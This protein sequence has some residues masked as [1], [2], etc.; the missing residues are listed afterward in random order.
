MV[1]EIIK[2]GKWMLTVGG[3][4]MVKIYLEVIEEQK[5]EKIMAR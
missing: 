5:K 3:G 4:R 2:C 1:I